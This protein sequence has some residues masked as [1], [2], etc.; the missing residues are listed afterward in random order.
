[1]T[2]NM[3]FFANGIVFEL[4]RRFF[5]SVNMY[6]NAT[7]PTGEFTDVERYIQR[8]DCKVIC[9]FF[10]ALGANAPDP[11]VIQRSTVGLIYV[12]I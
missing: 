9:E 5:F 12:D 8:A 2:V 3:N 7:Q 10:T 11:H 4:I 6:C 1:M